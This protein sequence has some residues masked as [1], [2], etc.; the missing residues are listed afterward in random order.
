MRKLPAL[1]ALSAL[2]IMQSC[3][4]S[5]NKAGAA[6]GDGV[7]L[8][9]NLQKGKSYTY[10]MNMDMEGETQG[11]KMENE[12]AFDY[13]V[14]VV[15]DQDSLKTLK[16][17]YD[18]IKME[19]N[20]GATNIDFDTNEPQKDSAADPRQNPMGMMSNMFY[21]MKGKS[22]EM[23]VNEKGEVKSVAGISELMN[24][25]INSM[26]VD[27]NTKQG[28]AQVFQSQFNEDAIK[29]SFSQAFNIFPDK[30]VKVGDTWT[31]TVGMPAMAGGNITTNY[32]VKEING[33]TVVLDVASDLSS[34]GMQGAQTGTMKVDATTG[35]VTEGNMEQKFTS[36]TA[37]TIKVV[38]KGT[39]K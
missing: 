35:L 9:F 19:M 29:S 38:I 7:A 13:T 2:L 8:K 32:K 1:V 16:T 36:P 17:T 5:D 25:V 3:N 26:Q 28:V 37:M 10:A 39:E 15:N 22:F 14:E 24:A 34:S 12:M 18:R 11:Q 27:E 6:N 21:A 30:P 31:K 23:K 20:A 4:S 33:N